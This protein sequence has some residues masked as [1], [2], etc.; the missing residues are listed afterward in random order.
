MPG[1][2]YKLVSMTSLILTFFMVNVV[3]YSDIKGKYS[4]NCPNEGKYRVMENIVREIFPMG[5]R[6][7][8]Q[9]Y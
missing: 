9:K 4:D 5:F 3:L 6:R 2:L 8:L 7:L 1:L